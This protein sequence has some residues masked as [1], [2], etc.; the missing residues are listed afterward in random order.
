MQHLPIVNRFV[1]PMF[2]CL[3]GSSHV[4]ALCCL[5]LHFGDRAISTMLLGKCIH[6]RPWLAPGI[7]GSLRFMKNLDHPILH[8]LG[9][10]GWL[11]WNT[12]TGWPVG[13]FTICGDILHQLGM[14]QNGDFLKY[15]YHI[16]PFNRMFRYKPTVFEYLHFRKSPIH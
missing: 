3:V 10:L 13:E 14:S 9:Q 12:A 8:Q 16:I 5:C 15:G 7:L 2:N 1:Y 11:G 6:Q 4:I